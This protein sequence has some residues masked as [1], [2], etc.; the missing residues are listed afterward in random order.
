[1]AHKLNSKKKSKNKTKNNC[2]YVKRIQED[3]YWD[4]GLEISNEC[5]DLNTVVNI[6]LDPRVYGVINALLQEFSTTEFLVYLNGEVKTEENIIE[7]YLNEV[8][9]PKQ[10]VSVT[11][12]DVIEPIPSLAVLHKH[13]GGSSFSGIDDDF[14]NSNH[15][16]SIVVDNNNMAAV[17]R[18]KAQCGRYL[19]VDANVGVGAIGDTEPF[20][21][22]AKEKIK[23]KEYMYQYQNKNWGWQNGFQQ[24]NDDTPKAMYSSSKVNGVPTL[25]VENIVKQSLEIHLTDNDV[26]IRSYLDCELSDTFPILWTREKIIDNIMGRV[27][28]Y[29]NIYGIK[30]TDNN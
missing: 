14:V 22:E 15:M 26:Y 18:I 1:L 24:R 7:M 3:E 13:P 19:K 28:T 8:L 23:E 25:L 2:Q 21:T 4:S 12:V 20:I 30:P 17:C 6:I 11:S 10:E 5:P 16:A 27:K 9:I 29:K